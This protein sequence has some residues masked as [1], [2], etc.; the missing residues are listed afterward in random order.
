MRGHL[1]PAAP[2]TPAPGPH[3]LSGDTG[4]RREG[5]QG[6]PGE[7]L[8]A[9]EKL[10]RRADFLRC[11]RTGRRRLG[12]LVIL[13]FAPNELGYPRIGITASRKVGN[14]VV[15]HRLKR[16]I[17]EIYRRWHGRGGLAAADLVMHLKTEAKS[18]G[19][20]D[21]KRDLL[22]LLNGVRGRHAASERRERKA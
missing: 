12:A 11:Y 20:G 15:R 2:V 7:R 4:A 1:G 8:L 19:F 9:R 10:L 6:P 21:M 17:K 3:D 5:P 14:A 13:Y 18:A 16:W 22:G